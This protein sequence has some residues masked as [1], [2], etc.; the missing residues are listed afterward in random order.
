MLSVNMLKSH[1]AQCCYAECSYAECT[2]SAFNQPSF[3]SD[4]YLPLEQCHLKKG[5]KKFYE[6]DNRLG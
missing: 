2:G 5:K 3:I 4:D 1:Y 6:I